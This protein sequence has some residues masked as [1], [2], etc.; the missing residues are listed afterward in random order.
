MAKRR[1]HEVG[2]EEEVHDKALPRKLA[3]MVPKK[4]SSLSLHL[5]KDDGK[6]KDEAWSSQFQKG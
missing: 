2:K 1:V 5:S 3:T 6:S 4:G